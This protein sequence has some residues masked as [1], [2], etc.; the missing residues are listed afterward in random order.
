[1][2]PG[3]QNAPDN[4]DNE[5]EQEENSPKEV[6]SDSPDSP[7]SATQYSPTQYPKVVEF[8]VDDLLVDLDDSFEDPVKPGNSEPAMADAIDLGIE[9]DQTSERGPETSTA[10][11]DIV[12][13]LANCN[14]EEPSNQHFS[15]YAN[16]QQALVEYFVSKTEKFSLYELEDLGAALACII[17]ENGN[18]TSILQL[19]E[20]LP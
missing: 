8:E 14:Q 18:Q 11:Q 7:I 3:V 2:L 10:Q 13:D 12:D 17:V 20:L 5:M 19:Q 6:A 16:D 1:M 4:H 15:L 9:I